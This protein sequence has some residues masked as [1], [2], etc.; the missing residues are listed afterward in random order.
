[1]EPQAD[2]FFNALWPCADDAFFTKVFCI[3]VAF[4]FYIETIA[5]FSLFVRIIHFV[6]S[7]LFSEKEI[8][9]GYPLELIFSAAVFVMLS[10]QT[11][12][13]YIRV[14]K[15]EYRK[16]VQILM[17][18]FFFLSLFP[19]AGLYALPLVA[20]GV[21]VTPL[22]WTLPFLVF[23]PITLFYLVISEFFIDISFIIGRLAYYGG[24]SLFVTALILSAFLG[25]MHKSIAWNPLEVARMGIITLTVVLLLLYSKDIWI[26]T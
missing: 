1:M 6:Y 3:L 21:P 17:T 8:N 24:L 20:F 11:I 2:D 7:M 25:V 14:K 23:M 18:G 22:E 19:F 26:I 10:I 15:T 13:L 4:F 16:I 5:Y 9:A 12:R